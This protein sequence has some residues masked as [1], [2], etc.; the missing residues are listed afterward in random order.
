MVFMRVVYAVVNEE[1]CGGPRVGSR[2]P[3]CC[4]ENKFLFV[5][6]NFSTNEKNL[7]L[8]KI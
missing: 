4:R 7:P 2:K 5:K 8:E 1:G 3:F 6:K